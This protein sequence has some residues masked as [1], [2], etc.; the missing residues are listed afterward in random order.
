M[1]RNGA[2]MFTS[3]AWRHSVDGEI[4]KAGRAGERRVVD[5]DVD[6][7]EIGHRLLDDFLGNAVAVT[8]PGT[9]SNA[10][11]PSA[12]TRLGARPVADVDGDARAALEKTRDGGAPEPARG[13]GDDGDAAGEILV[14]WGLI[15]WVFAVARRIWPSQVIR[16]RVVA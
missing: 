11:S 7:P 2:V 10:R 4:G 15:Q 1:N 14:P 16:D 3:I 12:A 5:E 13:A 8:S 6:A 9:A